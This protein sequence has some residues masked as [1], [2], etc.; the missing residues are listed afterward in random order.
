MQPAIAR[1]SLCVVAFLVVGL[2]F[3]ACTVPVAPPPTSPPITVVVV[4][5]ATP[6]PPTAAP[7]TAVPTAKPIEPTATSTSKPVEPTA[8]W[9]SK[10]ATVPPTLSPTST[11]SPIPPTA[12]RT[13]TP[14]ATLTPP[15]TRTPTVTPTRTRTATPT[16]EPIT[17][18][19]FSTYR[20]NAGVMPNIFGDKGD[21]AINTG[22]RMPAG[23][24]VF[25]VLGREYD[26]FGRPMSASAV[27]DSDA[28]RGWSVSKQNTDLRDYGVNIHWWY[29]A[30]GFVSLRIHYV[31]RQPWNVDC[32]VK[33]AFQE[34][35]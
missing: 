17:R 14:T 11:P 15:P 29:N 26:R 30:G 25:K 6:V 19:L 32:W 1:R 33:G 35:P 27:S 24:E 28:M 2:V 8:T 7:P 13:P 23:C 31:V 21:I 10:P 4:V 12:T 16:P 20:L 9:T 5:T 22:D 3:A 18:D 34:Q